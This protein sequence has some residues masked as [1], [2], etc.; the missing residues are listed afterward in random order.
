MPVETNAAI[1]IQKHFRGYVTRLKRLPAILYY[2]HKYLSSIKYI[3]ETKN[4]D[5]R[6][7]SCLDEDYISK[8]L[9]E[10]FNHIKIPKIRMWYDILVFDYLY[11][12]IPVNIKT[13]T[14]ITHDNTGNL[15]MCVHTYTNEILDYD[16]AYKNGNMSELLI[17][18]LKSKE[19][20]T[21]N[22]K[23]YYFIVINKSNNKVIVNSLKG[24]NTLTPNINN[25][26]FQICWKLNQDFK[27]DIIQNR[28]KQFIKCIQKPEASWREKFIQDF[29]LLTI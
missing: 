26:P 16:I 8:K 10:R 14:T 28:I 7:N 20:N 17:T 3:I 2:I 27:Y 1:I 19:Y 18:K 21:S 9:V 29:R 23:D 6:I 5:G 11:G 24:I 22:R 4:K 15:A 12:W 13:T 25:L